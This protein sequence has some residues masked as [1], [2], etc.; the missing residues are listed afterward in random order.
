MTFNH[1]LR[2]YRQLDKLRLACNTL[3][4]QPFSR[5]EA[6]ERA[7]MR[8]EEN[9]DRAISRTTVE[10]LQRDLQRRKTKAA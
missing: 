5:R 9:I 4:D 2:M 1:L 3:D 8:L 6:V 10:L 7:A